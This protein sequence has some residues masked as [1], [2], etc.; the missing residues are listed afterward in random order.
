M[1]DVEAGMPTARGAG[2]PARAPV[3]SQQGCGDS[4]T[5]ELRVVLQRPALAQH[6][7]LVHLRSRV[8]QQ[9]VARMVV[10]DAL[11]Q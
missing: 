9:H 5:D 6:E 7:Q 2:L 10:R 11:T 4:L 1:P 8:G 3:Q